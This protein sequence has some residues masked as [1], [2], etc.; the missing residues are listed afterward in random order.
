[1]SHLIR[2]LKTYKQTLQVT[3]TKRKK[4]TQGE[5]DTGIIIYRDLKITAI[6]IFIKIKRKMENFTRN[7]QPIIFKKSQMESKRVKGIT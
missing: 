6:N 2:N 3:E 1:M 4:Q 5:S 7:L